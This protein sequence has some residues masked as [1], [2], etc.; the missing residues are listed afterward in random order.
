MFYV[1]ILTVY[2]NNK[3]ASVIIL[4][5]LK[6]YY[7]KGIKL[8]GPEKIQNRTHVRRVVADLV[9]LPFLLFA[10][11]PCMPAGASVP[12]E[13]LA[14]RS[15][16]DPLSISENA[17]TR[18]GDKV[19]EKDMPFRDDMTFVMSESKFKALLICRI[20]EKR[21][22]A[23][24]GKSVTEIYTDDISLWRR[25]I[26]PVA[27]RVPIRLSVDRNVLSVDLSEGD[28]LIR[29]FDAGHPAAENISPDSDGD[30]LITRRV[31]GTGMICQIVKSMPPEE[32]RQRDYERLT[33]DR[34]RIGGVE[35][36][37]C[38]F[39]GV[40]R[41]HKDETV[42]EK[43]IEA[44]RKLSMNRVINVS[45]TGL[46]KEKFVPRYGGGQLIG[47]QSE[48]HPYILLSDAG[49][50]ATLYY[51]GGITRQ[52]TGYENSVLGPPETIKVIK[53]MA[54]AKLLEAGGRIGVPRDA[55]EN[56][57]IKASPEGVTIFIRRAGS[58]ELRRRR[59]EILRAIKKELMSLKEAGNIELID[60][61]DFVCSFGGIDIK[62]LSKGRSLIKLIKLK[63]LRRVIV[64]ADSVGTE[65]DP[66]NDRSMLSLTPEDLR[67]SGID[68]DVDIIK[69]YAG[70]E[71]NI[72]MPDGVI[73]IPLPGDMPAPSL[74]VYN[75]VVAA[76]EYLRSIREHKETLE[77]LEEIINDVRTKGIHRTDEM[78]SIARE[79][80][81]SLN[82]EFMPGLITALLDK[83]KNTKR[84]R[85]QAGVLQ[86]I[87][88]IVSECGT[89][90]IKD[91]ISASQII[92]AY[93]NRAD[94]NRSEKLP[95]GPLLRDLLGYKS[96]MRIRE[97]IVQPLLLDIE[98]EEE[99]ILSKYKRIEIFT[100]IAAQLPV[101]YNDIIFD[102]VAEFLLRHADRSD[103]D[104]VKA[105]WTILNNSNIFREEREDLVKG[106][107][108]PLNEKHRR[109]SYILLAGTVYKGQFRY[110]PRYAEYLDVLKEKDEN[111]QDDP[112]TEVMRELRA[113]AYE[114]FLVRKKILELRNRAGQ[115]GKEMVVVENLS[116]GAVSLAGI[117]ERRE[118]YR[119]IK[120]TG[121]RVISTKIASSG[122]DE[123]LTSIFDLKELESFA[124]NRPL[125]VVVD[126]T[127]NINSP[128]AG[129]AHMPVS[130][131]RG[132]M[133]IRAALDLALWEKKGHF[134]GKADE[135]EERMEEIRRLRGD[136]EF[137]RLVSFVKGM[138][139][140][141]A[142]PYEAYFWHP[143][144][145]PPD[146]NGTGG[147]K[148]LREV[149]DISGPSFIMI[150][151]VMDKASFSKSPAGPGEGH[152][153]G[154][155]DDK[156]FF[157]WLMFEYDGKGMPRLINS[158]DE[159]AGEIIRDLEKTVGVPF[160]RVYTD[161][162]SAKRAKEMNRE[163][164]SKRMEEGVRRLS[165]LAGALLKDSGRKIL[166]RIPVE[167]V[168]SNK[169][170]PVMD[171]LRSI[172]D[173]TENAG[174]ELFY[175]AG[176][177]TVDAGLYVEYGLR[178][179]KIYIEPDRENTVT[180]IPVFKGEI[181]PDKEDEA[182][183]EIQ[184]LVSTR[185]GGLH[186][187]DTQILPVAA[188][189]DNISLLRGVFLGLVLTHIARQKG[190][191]L[192]GGQQ[193]A[194]DP[195]TKAALDFFP[196][197]KIDEA[198]LKASD[199]V[200]LATGDINSA[201][202]VL[203]KLIGLLPVEPVDAREIYEN[204]IQVIRSA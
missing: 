61:A 16:F 94:F 5:K 173:E 184:R 110:I 104:I 76:I 179:S 18:E 97:E 204:A 170:S 180:F 93:L 86:I 90:I 185:T 197:G 181:D 201:I 50:T 100:E 105:L 40:D 150:Q 79:L 52:L 46:S 130:F 160:D 116:Y 196:P 33:E 157:K 182:R 156:G 140:Q 199:I 77:T 109:L 176:T 58:E 155:F 137:E 81:L 44:K 17:N 98:K 138:T 161:D 129:K 128:R 122:E 112:A 136:E 141:N 84:S 108:D 103:P 11:N 174:V 96:P 126:G 123:V 7:I 1:Y 149:S 188:Y 194:R 63:E 68:W 13:T 55:L 41:V 54:R 72:Q 67:D 26:E 139:P 64:M 117:T 127:S 24:K 101:E 162:P 145:L 85:T 83:L 131:T 39:D 4:R 66:G 22:Q 95:I 192:C 15:S 147:Y 48:T 21:A 56:T 53:D 74:I 78:L 8:M 102:E 57:E 62:P 111:G 159:K 82:D 9:I 115:I 125:I 177:G 195:R 191:G 153:P 121:I 198:G 31:P 172:Q 70:S 168:E 34:E 75:D 152:I 178:K 142:M 43:V 38:D 171:L 107:F 19:R 186:H 69:L 169:G 6:Q 118:G 47:E 80:P 163:K 203:K 32:G 133:K 113:A 36:I 135:A 73:K 12:S 10:I 87:E 154:Y 200:D 89:D 175:A 65:E 132:Y 120:N 49:A 23:W 106:R 190:S 60:S 30:V 51:K 29:Y 187:R 114:A 158:Y 91:K 92:E 35:A 2:L 193:L 143:G 202:L 124:K 146:I 189:N 165:A 28:L 183:R 148:E 14:V 27:G 59:F 134:P 20:I 25:S 167:A 88:K 71:R 151:S 42:S 99:N 144:D 37:I 3:E 119:Y 45:L 166:F 164:H